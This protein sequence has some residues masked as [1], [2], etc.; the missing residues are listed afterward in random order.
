MG[1]VT[2]QLDALDA[3]V[4]TEEDRCQINRSMDL[5]GYAPWVTDA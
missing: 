5:G 1:P 2:P 4:S 3:D